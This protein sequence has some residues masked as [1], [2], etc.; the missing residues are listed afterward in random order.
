M[1]KQLNAV[2]AAVVVVAVFAALFGW[3]AWRNA[4]SAPIERPPVAVSAMVVTP[5]DMPVFLQAVG[6]LS[7]V[8]EV[9]LSP[10]TSGR[11]V[12][13]DFE[14]GAKA[15]AGT[16]LVQLYDAPERADRA[17]AIAR[18][19]LATAQLKRSASLVPNGAESQ[20]VLD[21]RTAERDQALAEV[22]QLDARIE[23]KQIRAPF[24]GTLGIRQ[25][26]LGQY[27][28]PG[29]AIAT[30]SDTSELFVNFNVPQQQLQ[31]L[32]VGS[33]VVVTVDAWPGRR[34]SAMVNA[35]ESRVNR[36]TRNIAVQ[37]QLPNPDGALRPGMYVNAGL[38]LPA[39]TNALV[40]PSTAIQTTAAGDN[41]VV[42]RGPEA[43]RQ[44]QADYVRV[45]VGRRTGDK[46]IVT[47]GLEEGDVVVTEGQLRVQPGAQV[48]VV[49]L[50]PSGE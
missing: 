15:E 7:A 26:N 40:V 32:S 45:E 30:L 11:V 49:Q 5:T 42:V 6:S 24:T 22:Q 36:D 4:G 44:G 21:Q 12:A 9:L 31:Q 47:R 28:N 20:A 38:E 46:V 13:L 23:Q 14:A 39:E 1:L 27:L 33:T 29:D 25:V 48:Q 37:A 19:N 35:I 16:A 41:V 43:K 18:A 50:Q 17:A 2:I 34:F 8:R 3:R 10:E